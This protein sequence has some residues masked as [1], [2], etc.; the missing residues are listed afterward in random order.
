MTTTFPSLRLRRLRQHPGLR[1]LVTETALST[2]DFI[3]P[4]FVKAA[5]TESQ[6]ILS[7]PGNFQLTLADVV[8]QAR[9]IYQ[10]GIPAIILFG[11]P[12]YKDATGSAAYQRDG[13]VQ[14]AILA[15]KQAVPDLLVITDVCCCEYTDHGHCGVL[16]KHLENWMVDNDATLELLVKQ[17]ISHAKAGADVVA[18]SGMMDG[19]VG[20]IR[21]GLDKA[22]YAHVAILGY[23]V[24]YASAFYGP[25]R[26]AAESAPKLGDRSSYQMNPANGREALREAA[27][28]LQQGADM[29]MVKPAGAYLDVI[30]RVKQA[31]PDVPLAAYQVSGEFAMIKAAAQ[32]GWIEER[33][34]VMESLLAIKRAGADVILSYYAKDVAKWL[35]A[36]Q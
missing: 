24:K 36:K 5:L 14:Q 13:I 23:S 18:P 10:L 4:L 34:M 22:G 16:E 21:Q 9:E 30:Y 17:A 31:Y 19:A 35:R 33:R 6:P 2:R 11:I 12:S 1:D 29:L 25:F 7:M 3:M 15:I 28:D 27:M 8:K 32:N 20:A 26:E